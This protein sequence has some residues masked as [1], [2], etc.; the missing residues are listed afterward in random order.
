MTVAI[1]VPALIGLS[2]ALSP[3]F[4]W[5]ENALSDL[6]AQGPGAPIFNSALMLGGCLVF[7]FALGLGE[8][9]RDHLLGRLGASLLISDG[10]ALFAIGL[11]PETAGRVHS[12]VSVAFFVLLPFSLLPLG[13]AFVLTRRSRALGLYAIGASI[14]ALLV[15]LP[16]WRGVAIPEALASFPAAGWSLLVGVRMVKEARRLEPIRVRPVRSV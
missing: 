15:W 1:L 12:D 13:A 10:F 6:G 8:M 5:T 11:F 2:I 9:L 14:L 16:P 3:W 4:S 7:L